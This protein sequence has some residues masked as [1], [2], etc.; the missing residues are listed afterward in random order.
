MKLNTMEK[1]Y[2]CMRDRKPEITLDENLRQR[3]LQ[4][5][6]AHVGDELEVAHIVSMSASLDA[7]AYRELLASDSSPKI[8]EPGTLPPT[9]SCPPG[10]APAAN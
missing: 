8:L 2:L 6:R 5:H 4:P 9:R 7:S 10:S 1:L 3:A